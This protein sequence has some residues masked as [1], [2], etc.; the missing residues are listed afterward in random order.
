MTPLARLQE[1]LGEVADLN[2]AAAVLDWDQ[3]T[4]MPPGG[5]EDRANQVATLRRLAHERFTS[6]ETA[7]LL[8]RAEAEVAGLDHDSD[9]ASLVRV[10]RRDLEDL[11]RLPASLVADIARAATRAQ[12]VWREARARS[13]WSLFAPA[14]RTTVDLSRRVADALGYEER[15]YDALIRLYEPGLTTGRVEA[16]LSELREAIVP[17][18]RAVREHDDRVDD[19]LLDRPCDERSQLDFALDVIT[20]LGYDLERGRQDLSAHPF[21]TS[22]GPGDVR[23]TTRTGRT[24]GTSCLFSSIHES[25]HAMYDQGLPRALDRTPLWDGASAGIHES[26][27]RMWENLVCRGRPFWDWCFPRLREAFP[28]ALDGVDAAGF[29]RASNRVR[30]SYIRV[31][32]DEVTYNLHILLRFEIENALLEDRLGVDEVPEAWNARL[33]E[34]LGLDPPPDSQGALQDIHWTGGLGGFVGYTLGNLVSAQLM[35]A[36]RREVPDLDARFAAG[37]FRPLLD[38]L[39]ERVHRHGR[40]FTPDELT[41]RATGAPIQAGPWIAYVREKFGALYAL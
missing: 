8:E 38:W 22:F 3:E 27:S 37:E 14:M 1:A 26:Q 5:V 6:E 17:L 32:A 30:P 11:T 7:G 40:K 35:E 29:W 13:E 33:R 15:P 19:S 28:E 36:V 4:Y 21:C 39:R 9:E 41:E 31:D 12:P 24:L 23:V 34:Y 16:L 2:R 10:T 20:R 18:V 25:G